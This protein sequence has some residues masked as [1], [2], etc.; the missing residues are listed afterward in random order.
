M[1][2]CSVCNINETDEADYICL[3][4]KNTKVCSKCKRKLSK[5]EYY[6]DKYKKDGLIT[7][8]QFIELVREEKQQKPNNIYGYS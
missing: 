2:I 5:S 7:Q 8:E 4:C 6:N 1:N 3:E